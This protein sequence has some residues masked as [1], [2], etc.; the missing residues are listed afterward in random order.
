[1]AE[2]PAGA[3]PDAGNPLALSIV[4]GEYGHTRAVSDGTIA[5]AGVDPE[6]IP[7]ADLIAAFRRMVREVAFDVCELA[8]TTY[9]IARA[10][11]APYVALPIFLMRRFHHE[12]IV[13]RPDAGIVKPTDLHGKRVGVRAYTV[14]SGVWTRGMLAKFY[15]VDLERVTWVVDDED[16]VPA[17]R[18]PGNVVPAPSGRTLAD[19]LADGEIQAALS[20]PAGLGAVATDTYTRLFPEFHARDQEWFDRTGIYPIHGLLVVKEQIIEAHPWLAR[21]LFD[22]FEQARAGY[23]SQL[24]AGN[25]NGAT[26][27]IYRRHASI[28]GDPLPYGVDTNRTAID[29][30]IAFTYDQGLVDKAQTIESLFVDPSV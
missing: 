12:A 10:A 9:F 17:M 4:M 19:M 3:A 5:I 20:G 21:A 16:H 23:V 8:P 1:M 6:F 27:E 2:R 28:V 30:L 13:C 15:G 7:T 18:L 14:T 24:L 22:A 25:F 26:D 11:G 29:A